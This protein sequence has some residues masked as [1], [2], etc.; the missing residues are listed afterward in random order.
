MKK[1]DKLIFV[2]K[3][4]TAVSPMAEAIMQ[5]L[6]KL[7]DILI[8]SKGIVVLFPE[9]V[10]PKAEAILASHSLTMKSHTSEPIVVDDFDQRT[11]IL[12]MDP[13]QKE[14]IV[15]EFHRADNLFTLPEYLGTE[16]EISDPYGG[17][18]ADYGACF[19]QLDRMLK[20]LAEQLRQEDA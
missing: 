8:V 19:E 15:S 13:E 20:M 12:A 16:D 7:D 5:E 10:N 17:T 6:L 18:L 14:M 11:L 1:Y 9:P 2:C 3:T 4:N